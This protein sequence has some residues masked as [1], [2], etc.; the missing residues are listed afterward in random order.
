MKAA[1]LNNY[2]KNGT[3]LEVR[4]MALPSPEDHEVLVKVCTAAVNPLDN[5]IV[6]GEVKLIVPYKLPLI[7]GNEFAGIVEKAGASVTKFKAGDRVYGRMPL[8]KIGAFAEYAAVAENALA[9]IPDYLS[10]DEAA[11]I[12]LT[13]LTA[14]QAFEIMKPRSGETIFISGG[15][16][17]LGAMAIPIA[18]SLGLTVYTNGSADNEERVKELGAD[19]FIDYKKENYTEVLKDVDYVLDTL[20]DRELPNEF[21]VLKRGGSLVSLRG[22]PNGRFAKRAGLSFIKQLLFKLAGS[23]YDK[24]AAAKNQT[25]DFLF[26]HEDGGQLEELSKIFNAENPL[27]TSIDTIYTLSQV[28][29]ALDKVKQGKS[30]GKTIIKLVEK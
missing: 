24:I 10:F 15:T 7:M 4:E 16:G 22:L 30:K 25:Y 2:D 9:I 11:T 13:A 12:P 17:S 14:M 1:V 5:M 3:K 20:G 19:R 8:A 27:E 26:V 21:K 18:K 29:E 28:N 23:K 6:R